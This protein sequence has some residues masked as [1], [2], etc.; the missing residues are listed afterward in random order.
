MMAA[1]EMGFSVGHYKLEEPLGAGGMGVVFRGRD[2]RKD[3]PVAVKI[4]TPGRVASQAR[5]RARESALALGDLSHPNIASVLDFG[6]HGEIDYLVMEY[7]P[8][9]TLDKMLESERL[10]TPRVIALGGQLANGL[11]AAHAAGI[12]HRDIKPSNLRITDEGQLKIVDFGVATYGRRARRNPLRLAEVLPALAGTIQYMAPERLLG[13][14]ANEGTDIFSAGSVLYEMACGRPIV[15]GPQPI[16]QIHAMLNSQPPRPT[17]LNPWIEPALESVILS[18]IERDPARRYA[19]AAD[20][21]AALNG[22]PAARRR[23]PRPASTLRAAARW[24]GRLTGVV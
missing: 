6:S 7:V 21:A 3:L 14:E 5:A 23:S 4:L 8:G 24:A 11:A 15:T 1:S 20:M 17:T 16:R 12:I 18:A 19:S 10:D 13:V 9:T 22:L 2:T